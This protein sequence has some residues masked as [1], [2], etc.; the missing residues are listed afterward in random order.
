MCAYACYCVDARFKYV[1]KPYLVHSDLSRWSM[2]PA[3]VIMSSQWGSFSR[4]VTSGNCPVYHKC[5]A[6]FTRTE[7]KLHAFFH[8]RS[9]SLRLTCDPYTEALVVHK[10]KGYLNNPPP[11][12]VVDR[13]RLSVSCIQQF[14]STDSGSR[15]RRGTDDEPR[16]W[17]TLQPRAAFGRSTSV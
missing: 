11:Q 7:F 2:T 15:Q 4:C 13:S 5:H 17:S 3:V 6:I 14:A 12:R 10:H 9:M 1:L 16:E 8:M